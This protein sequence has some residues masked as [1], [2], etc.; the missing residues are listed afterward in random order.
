MKGQQLGLIHRLIYLI[1]SPTKAEDRLNKQSLTY[2]KAQ[3]TNTKINLSDPG[4]LV[5]S[6]DKLHH[7]KF[8]RKKKSI[9]PV[10]GIQVHLVLSYTH[11]TY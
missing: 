9:S 1:N 6:S 5:L 10:R 2:H 3:T 4:P 7:R 8:E 11:I